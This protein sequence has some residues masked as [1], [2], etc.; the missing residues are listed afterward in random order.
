MSYKHINIARINTGGDSYVEQFGWERTVAH[1]GGVRFDDTHDFPDFCRG[2]SQ[3][4]AH[5]T[6]TTI[7]RCNKGVST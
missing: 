7:G 6:H 4:G 5:P 1:S 2:Q 3:T